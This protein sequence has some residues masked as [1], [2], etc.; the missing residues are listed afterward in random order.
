MMSLRRDDQA[1]G[2]ERHLVIL[3]SCHLVTRRRAYTL[4]ELLLVL[5]LLIVMAAIAYPTLDSLYADFRLSSAADQVR[6]CWA[7][8]RAH[9]V[10]EGR[11]YRFAV[12]PERGNFRIA[13]DGADY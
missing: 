4:F 8:G 7:E 11:P 12:V 5:A 2:A 13:P 10:E 1:T 3:S 9:A 6:A